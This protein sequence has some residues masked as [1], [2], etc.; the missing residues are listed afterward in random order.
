ML[1]RCFLVM[2]I[3]QIYLAGVFAV[4][5]P[6]M[7]QLLY[8][9]LTTWTLLMYTLVAKSILCANVIASIYSLVEFESVYDPP[10]VDGIKRFS[11]RK[12]FCNSILFK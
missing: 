7:N 6:L 12:P 3:F 1:S 10:I 9:I 2:E 4:P 5:V 8:I 11:E